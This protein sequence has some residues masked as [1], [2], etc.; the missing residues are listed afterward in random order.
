MSS[1]LHIRPT[2]SPA[3]KAQGTRHRYLTFPRIAKMPQP[4]LESLLL[5]GSTPDPAT[6][7]DWEF[8]GF[9]HNPITLLVRARRFRKAFQADP[10]Y[11]SEPSFLLGYNVAV[12]PG[13]I[14]DPYIAAPSEGKPF[15]HSFYHVRPCPTSGPDHL[16][17]HALFLN[18][19]TP[20]Q[21]PPFQPARFLRSYLVQPDPH[22]P[23]LLLGKAYAALA[24]RRLFA[25]FFVL[26]RYNLI[27]L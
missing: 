18:Y 10:A 22:N 14:T 25:G 12:H 11:P 19:S 3:P 13:L 4:E 24:D 16:Y 21:N 8:R 1:T 5:R 6:L 17:P 26:E 23:D 7:V 15:R 27:G 20:S 2:Q 9:S